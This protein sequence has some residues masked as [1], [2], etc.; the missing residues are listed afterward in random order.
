MAKVLSV[1]D[2]RQA[3]PDSPRISR[4]HR[5]RWS[6][7]FYMLSSLG[8]VMRKLMLIERREVCLWDSE[9]LWQA[10]DERVQIITQAKLTV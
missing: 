6:I 2:M 4:K 5:G 10:D 1:E 9:R 7:P 3:K 8:W